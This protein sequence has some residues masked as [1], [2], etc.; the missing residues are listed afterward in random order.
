MARR[1]FAVVLLVPQPVATQVDVLR[2]ALGVE[3]VERI[4][5]HVTLVPPVNI[6]VDLVDD[7][8]ALVRNA[9][10]AAVPIVATLGPVAT[11]CR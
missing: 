10:A 5:P 2:H 3:D 11:S 6:A 8:L 1:R 9:A 7:A 4:A